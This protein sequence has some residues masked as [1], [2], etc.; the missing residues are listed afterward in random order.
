MKR[1]ILAF[2]FVSGT[3]AA[4]D[5]ENLEIIAIQAQKGDVL[6]EVSNSTWTVWKTLGLQGA[7][8]TKSYQ[9]IAQQAFATNQKITLRFPLGV[10][11]DK[12]DYATVPDMIRIYKP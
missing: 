8:S 3:A 4:G 2:A 1:M 5:C 9:A 7:E 12:T 6:I 11:C 10:E